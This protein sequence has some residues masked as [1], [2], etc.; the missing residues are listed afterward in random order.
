MTFS[1][2]V[3]LPLIVYGQS[4]FAPFGEPTKL[5]GGDGNYYIQPLCS[6]DGSKIAFTESNYKGLWLMNSDGSNLNQIS[7][8]IGAGYDFVWSLDSQEI[9]TRVSKYEGKNR[10]NAIKS[11]N[12]KNGIE[13]NISGYIKDQLGT[14]KL[15]IDN[16]RIYYL[17]NNKLEIVDTGL[18]MKSVVESSIVYQLGATI[19]SVERATVKKSI[20]QGYN[21][22]IYLY[23]RIS[24]DG[25]KLSY[26]VMGGNLY[27]MNMDGSGVINLGIGINARWSPDSRYLVYMINTDDGHRFLTSDIYVMSVDGRENYQITNTDDQ[28]EMN[29]AWSA[30]GK[31]IVFNTYK[32]GAIYVIKVAD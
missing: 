18:L 28:I 31:Q 6:P 4:K 16:S 3:L 11:F 7:K 2:M 19:Y 1:F 21:N 12:I 15:T 27:V 5:A 8:E 25:K 20:L 26:K 13:T 32:D 24:P 10:I 23:V 17:K 29:P 9:L 30:D 22:E 14:P